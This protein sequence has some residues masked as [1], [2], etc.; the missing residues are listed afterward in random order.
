MIAAR[1]TER[2]LEVACDLHARGVD[3]LAVTCDVSQHQE[4]EHLA[5][6]AMTRFG[7]VDILVNTAGW[8][9]RCR[10]CARR[11]SSSAPSSTSISTASTGWRRRMS[12]SGS[13][14]NI[15]SIAAFTSFGKPQAAYTASKAAVVG[16][17]EDLAQQWTGRIGVRVNA[18]AAGFVETEMTS[19]ELEDGNFGPQAHLVPAGRG[20]RPEEIAAAVVFLASDAASYVSGYVLVV[21]GGRLVF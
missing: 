10:R 3:V 16:L 20:G 12:G 14:I 4:C 19:G 8:A 7:R 21:D 1:R 17:T 6:A 13:I 2:L 11:R 18:L 15:A 5:E 9:R